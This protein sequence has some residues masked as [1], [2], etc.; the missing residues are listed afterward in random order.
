MISEQSIEAIIS[1]LK[2]KSNISAKGW[3]YLVGYRDG[4]QDALQELKPLVESD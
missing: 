4:V 2:E 1:E 3:D